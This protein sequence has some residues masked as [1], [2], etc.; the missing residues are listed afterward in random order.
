MCQAN[1]ASDDATGTKA[2]QKCGSEG[3]ISVQMLP[4]LGKLVANKLL[5]LPLARG[6]NRSSYTQLYVPFFLS[7]G[8]HFAGDFMCEKGMVY[9]PFRFF[10]LQAVAITFEDFVIH[11][12]KCFLLARGTL[13]SLGRK[14]SQGL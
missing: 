5:K 11:L 8:F 2:L 3:L 9:R 6:T 14:W 10:P 4:W 13:T 12:A 7:A 1:V